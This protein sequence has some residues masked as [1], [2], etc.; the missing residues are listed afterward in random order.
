MNLIQS[1]LANVL[2]TI[3]SIANGSDYELDGKSGPFAGY[4]P[5]DL[6]TL[7]IQGR[8]T[9]KPAAAPR[10]TVEPNPSPP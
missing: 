6:L 5:Y 1:H 3:T 7:A 2:N 9:I 8:V 4:T 10:S